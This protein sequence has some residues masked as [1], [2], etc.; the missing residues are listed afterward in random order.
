MANDLPGTNPSRSAGR[1]RSEVKCHFLTADLDRW[2]GCQTNFREAFGV[3]LNSFQLRHRAARQQER[4]GVI[5]RNAIPIFLKRQ[6]RASFH[7]TKCSVS[8]RMVNAEN[9]RRVQPTPRQGD[10]GES[11]CWRVDPPSMRRS[12]KIPVLPFCSLAPDRCFQTRTFRDTQKPRG[13]FSI[14]R[15]LRTHRVGRGRHALC[16]EPGHVRTSHI[17]RKP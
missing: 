15:T 11:R 7:R 14:A 1:V 4:E 16:T 13:I 3:P 12:F 5:V 10:C 6:K 8:V 17:G 2:D 9:R